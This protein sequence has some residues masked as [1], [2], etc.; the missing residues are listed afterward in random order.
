MAYAIQCDRCGHIYPTNNLYEHP[1]V[2]W[3]NKFVDE[4]NLDLCPQCEQEFFEWLN[5]DKQ[6]VNVKG[7]LCHQR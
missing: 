2:G 7:E 1:Q 5:R 6:I 3:S 4:T